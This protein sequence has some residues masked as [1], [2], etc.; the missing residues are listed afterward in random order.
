M[1]SFIE[2]AEKALEG[3]TPGPWEVFRTLNGEAMLGIGDRNAEGVFDCGF[4]VWRGEGERDANANFIAAAPALLRQAITDVRARDELLAAHKYAVEGMQVQLLDGVTGRDLKIQEL[5]AKNG[6][7]REAARHALDLAK[8]IER[9][10][11]IEGK[12]HVSGEIVNTLRAALGSDPAGPG[13]N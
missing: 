1:S 2:Q 9:V 12:S 13:E 11:R 10:D 7:L 8:I 6:K 3:I 4:G 5:Q